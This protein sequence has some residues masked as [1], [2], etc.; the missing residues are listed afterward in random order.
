MRRVF[1]QVIVENQVHYGIEFSLEE[2]HGLTCYQ[3]TVDHDSTNGGGSQ[4]GDLQEIRRF[5]GMRKVDGVQEFRV[6]WAQTWMPESD[7]GGARELVEE[8]NA[9]LSVRHVKKRGQGKADIVGEMPPKRRRGR[10]RKQS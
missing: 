7:L 1:K 4:P 5:T 9:D 10:P 3:H 8:F 2:P 6:A